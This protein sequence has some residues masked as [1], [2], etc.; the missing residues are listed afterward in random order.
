MRS[1]L[2]NLVITLFSLIACL[3][4]GESAARFLF[5]DQRSMDVEIAALVPSP[6]STKEIEELSGSIMP[7]MNWSGPYGV[8]LNPNV[9]ALIKNHTLSG[10]DVRIQTNSIGLRYSELAPKQIS[11][12]RILF[13]GDSITFGH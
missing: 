1:L 10:R 5:D 6:D 4:I 7:V 13:L 8:R 9:S 3:L 2:I 11:K 12:K